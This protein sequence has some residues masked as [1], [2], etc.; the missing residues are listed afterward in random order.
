MQLGSAVAVATTAPIRPLA[1][2]PPCAVS[3]ALKSEKKNF[4]LRI[5]WPVV[6]GVNIKFTGFFMP[7]PYP[8]YITVFLSAEK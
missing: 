4:F 3:A 2:G 6:N 7:R 5:K 8:L 1:L